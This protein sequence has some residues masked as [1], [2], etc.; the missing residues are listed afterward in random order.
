MKRGRCIASWSNPTGRN[1][2][3]HGKL[4][5]SGW[6][7]YMSEDNKAF[8]EWLETELTG[9]MMTEDDFHSYVK[10]WL[11]S[12]WEA[13]YLAGVAEGRGQAAKYRVS[14]QKMVESGNRVKWVVCLDRPERPLD[15]K[16][17]DKG[18]ITP[19]QSAIL[20][21]ANL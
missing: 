4:S 9:L 17:W 7:N 11:K 10:H 3:R 6:R 1:M 14:V 2:S 12:A 13:A 18:R 21:H 8:E 16:P 15:A 5:K 20:E 19:F